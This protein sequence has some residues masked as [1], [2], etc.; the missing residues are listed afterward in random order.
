M[1]NIKVFAHLVDIPGSQYI[2]EELADLCIKSEL[3]DNAEFFF[4]CNYNMENFEWLREKFKNYAN[5]HYI[6]V[7]ALPS[8]YEIPTMA[9]IKTYCDVIDEE[10]YILFVHHKGVTRLDNTC[11]RDWRDMMTY[12]NVE[13]WRDCVAKLDEGYDT[14]GIN[15]RSKPVDHYS[16]TFFWARS[17]YIKKLPKLLRPRDAQF[18][19]QISSDILPSEWPYRYEG[20]MWVA[21]AKPNAYS[22][23][24]SPETTDHYYVN[25]PKELYRT[26]VSN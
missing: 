24:D 5:V 4:Y 20:E 25:W 17:G 18:Q 26:D 6:D 3:A 7:G 9:D 22:M 16:G 2:A 8:E 12:F 1:P 19:R 15:W 13:R 23:Y 10:A 21:L 11:V 14:V